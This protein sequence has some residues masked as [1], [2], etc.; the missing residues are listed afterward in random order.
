MMSIGVRPTIGGVN[1]II[2]V[3]IFDFSHDIYGKTLRVYLKK[4]LRAEVKFNS[5]EELTAQLH[6]DKEATLAVFA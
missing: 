2:E 1:R 3:N 4:Y 5:L 6:R